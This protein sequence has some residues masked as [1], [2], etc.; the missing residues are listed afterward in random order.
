MA[1]EGTT[2]ISSV[3]KRLLSKETNCA[4]WALCQDGTAV[5]PMPDSVWILF[6]HLA[7]G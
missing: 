3:S 1:K 2:K 5:S 6:E 7:C 4:E